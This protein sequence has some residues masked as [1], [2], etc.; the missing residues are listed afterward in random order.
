M[1][2]KKE[3]IAIDGPAASGK[4]TIADLVAKNLNVPYISTGNM[5]RT[6]TY[7]MI[8][9]NIDIDSLNNESVQQYLN[10]INLEYKQDVGKDNY[11]VFLDGKPVGDVIRSHEVANSVSIVAMIKSVRVW[12]VEKQR[13]L[14]ENKMVLMEGRDIGT[15]VFP[16]AKYKFFLTASPEV[17]AKRRL[18]QSNENIDG[19]TIESV[20]AEIRERD[21]R[22]M[23][24][25][26]SPLKQADDAI[27]VDSSDMTINEVLN[28]IIDKIS[29]KND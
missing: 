25:K 7:Y 17:R 10:K 1:K 14:A 9:N 27:L 20:A 22:D 24:R 5:Y 13:L 28:Y 23:N 8:K 19:A 4:S 11:E 16:N 29:E 2:E 6:I 15:E 12:L 26:I 21:E 18:G 3:I